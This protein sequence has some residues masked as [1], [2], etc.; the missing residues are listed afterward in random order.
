MQRIGLRAERHHRKGPRNWIARS[1]ARSRRVAS[2][3]LAATPSSELPSLHHRRAPRGTFGPTQ[4]TQL[5]RTLRDTS[6]TRGGGT[7]TRS[8]GTAILPFSLVTTPVSRSRVA[9][10]TGAGV[11]RVCG[12][13]RA[14]C[15]VPTNTVAFEIDGVDR[16]YHLG[17]SVLAVGTERD[18]LSRPM[19]GAGFVTSQ[20]QTS[21]ARSGRFRP[22]RRTCGSRPHHRGHAAPAPTACR[23]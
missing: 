8:K 5:R 21:V 19:I 15:T 20:R 22:T 16:P 1:A 6:E 4:P 11:G 13:R 18:P 23:G 17:C 7:K 10:R 3:R 12:R 2:N 14:S 9:N